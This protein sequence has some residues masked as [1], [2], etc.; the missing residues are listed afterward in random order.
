MAARPSESENGHNIMVEIEGEWHALNEIP[1]QK[2]V[3]V[4]RERNKVL[5]AIDL[6]ALVQDLQQTGKIIH[7]AYCG[8]AAELQYSEN[9]ID[10]MIQLQR[11][12]YDITKLC[13]KSA[14]TVMIFKDASSTIL[15]D[16]QSTYEYLLENMEEMAVHTFS[17][18]LHIADLM[19]NE[20]KE[21]KEEFEKE[22]KKVIEI[23]QNTQ[24]MKQGAAEEIEKLDKKRIELEAEKEQEFQLM[25]EHQE[26]EREAERRSRE[27]EMQEDEAHYQILANYTH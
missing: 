17:S 24:K 22:E 5:E 9:Q 11:L 27:L 20:A 26:K 10:N 15:T 4:L 14:L 1:D 18:I 23:Q 19:G 3:V 21:L 6:K 12:G 16:L 7:I 13:D 25:K 8:A 2:S